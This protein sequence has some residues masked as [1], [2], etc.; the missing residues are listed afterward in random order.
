MSTVKGQEC[1]VNLSETC[2]QQDAP[3][4]SGLLDVVGTQ[5]AQKVAHLDEEGGDQQDELVP[6]DEPGQA[7]R[8][9]APSVAD[10]L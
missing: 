8:C 5:A 9:A 2:G 7:I 4:D 6:D 1:T 3:A 10:V